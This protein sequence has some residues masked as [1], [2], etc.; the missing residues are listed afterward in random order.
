MNGFPAVNWV[1]G[2]L[3]PYE[4]R[5][6]FWSRFCTLNLLEI[7]RAGAFFGFSVDEGSVLKLS[8]VKRM[9][10]ILYEPA[11]IL[12]TVFNPGTDF[13]DCGAYRFRIEFRPADSFRYCN[14]C[15]KLGYHSNLHE[16][17]WLSCCPFHLI[18]LREGRTREFQ[19]GRMASYVIAMQKLMAERGI[20]WPLIKK[21]S[22]NFEAMGCFSDLMK[23]ISRVGA[24]ARSLSANE[25]WRSDSERMESTRWALSRFHGIEPI[26][27]S[28]MP[29]IKEF[30]YHWSVSH[31][32]FPAGAR[33]GF[34]LLKNILDFDTVLEFYKTISGN[35]KSNTSVKCK[36]EMA[37]EVINR[38]HA[39]CRC[40][41]VF[42]EFGWNSSWIRI[43]P[44][45]RHLWTR[46]CPYEVAL[47]EMNDGWGAIDRRRHGYFKIRAIWLDISR[48][49]FDA[50]LIRYTADAKVSPEG[51]LYAGE[52]CWRA[53]EWND[54]S[55]LTS[56]INR[57]AEFEIEIVLSALTEWLDEIDV[58]GMPGWPEEPIDFLRLS[59]TGDGLRLTQWRRLGDEH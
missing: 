34:F 18:E 8:D 13:S 5:A 10:E 23:W 44:R 25:I 42:Q 58:G 48:R 3:R 2:T 27:K 39:H 40:E 54:D 28:V 55:P 32:D 16:L 59:D 46:P 47:E 36:I 24:K 43:D 51:Y 52:N 1:P 45:E 22:P 4:S 17:A 20:S 41:W 15:V 57:V 11:A 26:P 9:S 30:D 35:S 12:E 14:E 29:I 49:M 50:N 21:N 31:F 56:L 6:S 19:K 37:R 53:C 33:D 7:K 38:K